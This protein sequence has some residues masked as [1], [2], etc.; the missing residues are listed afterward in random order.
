ARRPGD[1]QL[2]DVA[3]AVPDLPYHRGPGELH[4]GGRSAERLGEPTHLRLPAA[5]L[6][7][8]VM[9]PVA[10]GGGRLGRAPSGWNQQR[11]APGGEHCP[12]REDHHGY[13]PPVSIDAH[14]NASALVVGWT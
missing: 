12:Q 10:L 6:E 11:H 4:P 13:R 14:R 2:P 3:L 5:E 9:L 8:E 7:V 1:V